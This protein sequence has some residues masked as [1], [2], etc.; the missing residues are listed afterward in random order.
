MTTTL[1]Q[2]GLRLSRRRQLLA[3]AG[4]ILTLIFSAAVFAHGNATGIVKER[5]DMMEKLG[6][7]MKALKS[8][9]RSQ[10]G[11]DPGKV[12]ELASGI[13]E[14]S[15]HIGATFPEGSNEAPSEALPAIWEDWDRFTGLIEQMNVESARLGE[16]ARDGDKRSVMRQFVKL[17]KTCRG[18]HTDFRLKKE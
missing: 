5:M 11:F 2:S 12:A 10:S 3:G 7:N 14:V 4:L 16:I 6:K 15:N 17:G 9:V 1:I 13:E 8:L 18:C